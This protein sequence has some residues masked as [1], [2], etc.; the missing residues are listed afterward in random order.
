MR[1]NRAP[2]GELPHAILEKAV[3]ATPPVSFY[4][5]FSFGFNDVN[6]CLGSELMSKMSPRGEKVQGEDARE[7]TEN[8][9]KG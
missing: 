3:L 2:A 8:P 7:N 9:G 1:C 6:F 5:P 4:H